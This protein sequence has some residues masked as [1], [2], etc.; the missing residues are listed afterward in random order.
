M[1]KN[2][3]ILP[4]LNANN[5]LANETKTVRDQKLTTY[6]NSLLPD[7][8]RSE[9]SVRSR[10]QDMESA[11]KFILAFNNGKI[12]GSTGRGEWFDLTSKERSDIGKGKVSIFILIV[13]SS[14]ISL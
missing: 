2:V 3:L 7:E 4:S 10:V 8:Q 1:I 11:F 5:F 12:K 9:R 6:F 14:Y 13:R